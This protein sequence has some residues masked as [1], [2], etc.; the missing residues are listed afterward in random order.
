MI[1]K[2]RWLPLPAVLA[3]AAVLAFGAA[4]AP[5]QALAA[6]QP[7]R[8]AIA[9]SH[10]AWAS[11][12]ADAGQVP[13]TTAITARVYLAGRDPESL[14]AY[15][16][17]VS[18]PGSAAYGHYLTPA[19]YQQRFGP[20]AAQVSAVRQWLTGAGMHVTGVTSR[21]VA[22]S[23]TGQTAAV[24]FGAALHNYRV[25]GTLQ[26]APQTSVTVPASVAPAVLSVLGL[27][28]GTVHMTPDI[29]TS[30][31]S[32]TPVTSPAAGPATLHAAASGQSSPTET[33][34]CS[35]Y[36]GQRPATTLPPAY[37][38]TL[39]YDLC[40]YVPN[41]LRAAYGVAGSGLTGKGA[42]IA[43][44]DPGASP[45]IVQDV[46]T[47][48]RRHGVQP[49]RPGQLTQYL[50]SDLASSC[51][52]TQAPYGEEHLD[53]EAA[54]TMA[55]DAKL[56]YVAMDCADV[57][58]TVLDAEGLIVDDHLA[59]IVSDSWHAG[60]ES[61]M[62]PGFVPALEQIFEQGAVEGIGF[63]FSSGDHGDWSPFT[64]NGQT[65]VQYPGSDPWVTSVGGTSL[66]TGPG[67]NYKWET[68]W[69]DDLAPLSADGTS[70]TGLPGQ[71]GG[72]T[73]GGP[74]ELFA[75]P[76]YQH[77]IVPDSL[78]HPAGSATAMRVMPDIAADADP[79]TG[80]L[81]GFTAQ[82]T[83][84]SAPQYVEQAVGGTS[85]STP[86]I[87]GI[88]ADVE[89]AI[90]A[91]IGFA[92]PAIY[93]RYGSRAYHDVTDDPLGPGELIAAADAAPPPVPPG[94]VPDIAVTM[95]HDTSL[96]ATPGY[97]DVTGVG[98]PTPDYLRSYSRR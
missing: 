31:A 5:G 71:F 28:S 64:P 53:F 23:G 45:T 95:A 26:R 13:S 68:G 27:A 29:S 91:P 19:Q 87:A 33:R 73:G 57:P 1:A 48:M 96:R 15:A 25:N 80:M 92:N 21:Y 89:Q 97:D 47:Y 46:N 2:R 75:Q 61:Q 11:Q 78:S 72:G 98:S 6:P 70:W 24:A 38:Q 52:T 56:V 4:V 67:G 79:A 77:G 42:T 41:Q 14:A 49:L 93:E 32:V 51:G 83:A 12:A 39:D 63:Y 69:G 88:Q 81:I 40:G 58:A 34:A 3:P 76:F 82:P 9:D 62:P 8:L 85:E 37:G 10:P 43:V 84:T 16:Q 22:V 66:A 20:T 59:D 7:P 18:D 54:H 44:V 35:E 90:G 94:A 86:L 50:P 36:W 74:S 17:Q 60:I 55:P 65:A 30:P